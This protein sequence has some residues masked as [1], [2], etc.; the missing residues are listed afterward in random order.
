LIDFAESQYW[1]Y[2]HDEG[3]KVSRIDNLQQVEKSLGRKPQELQDLP[4]LRPELSYIWQV[5]LDLNNV[6]NGKISYEE[7]RHYSDIH[8]ELSPFEISAIRRLSAVNQG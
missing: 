7:L 3:S 1:L 2:G 6:D 8:G 4:E 5:F